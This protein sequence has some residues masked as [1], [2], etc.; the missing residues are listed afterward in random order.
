VIWDFEG[1]PIPDDL[2]EDVARLSLSPPAGLAGLVTDAE[3]AA[4]ATRA[5]AMVRRPIFP[6]A[7]SARA[8]PWPLI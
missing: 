7:R 6:A 5:A 3:L 4:L 8:F 1:Q 2:L